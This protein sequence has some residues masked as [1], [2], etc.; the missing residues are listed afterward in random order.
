MEPAKNEQNAQHYIYMFIRLSTLGFQKVK[1]YD[2]VWYVDSSARVF[3]PKDCK[4][5]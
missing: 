3:M 2:T 5:G 4:M 1:I